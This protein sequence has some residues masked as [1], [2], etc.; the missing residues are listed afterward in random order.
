MAVAALE[1]SDVAT[2]VATKW[3]DL[4]SGKSDDMGSLKSSVRM[5]RV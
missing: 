5:W 1:S 4:I 2:D 3:R